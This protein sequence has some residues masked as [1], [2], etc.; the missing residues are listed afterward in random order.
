MQG[1][2]AQR[3]SGLPCRYARRRLL[4]LLPHARMSAMTGPPGDMH[5]VLRTSDA[6]HVGKCDNA[7]CGYMR[8]H[9]EHREDVL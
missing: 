5:S 1:E 9:A 2:A 3:L 6:G 7:L 4:N 8:Q